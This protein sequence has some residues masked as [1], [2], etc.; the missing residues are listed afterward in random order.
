[1]VFLPNFSELSIS[2]VSQHSFGFPAVQKAQPN[3]AIAWTHQLKN[4]A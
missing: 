2:A 4:K 3:Y 1:M